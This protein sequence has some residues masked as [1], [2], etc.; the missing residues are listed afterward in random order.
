MGGDAGVARAEDRRAARLA[1]LRVAAGA[2]IALVA[3]AGGVEEIGAARA[4]HQVAAERR[5][6]AQ[7][8]RGAGERRL[9]DQRIA[10]ATAS[11]EIGV[12]RQRADAAA[13][14][15][16]ASRWRRAPRGGRYGR[17]AP[18]ARRRPS[19]DRRDWCRRPD[20]RAP[21]AAPAARPRRGA[22][23]RRIRRRS[24]HVLSALSLHLAA[25]RP[26]P[27]RRC[28]HRRRSGTGCRSSPS[29]IAL[30][31]A[32]VAASRRKAVALMIWPGVQK[33]HCSASCSTNAACTGLKR[34]RLR[35]SLDGQHLG[36]VQR[37]GEDR[38]RN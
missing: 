38:G 14:V 2:G 26:A 7:L 11:R 36:A 25:R 30:A 28:R 22:R 15:R 37:R 1:A 24:C 4:L 8:R 6:V 10:L 32:P 3:G 34:A 20:T 27:L 35:H 17:A 16:P 18:G 9:G 31:V 29:R 33:P 19:S 13:A 21:G 23:R 5:G 12:A